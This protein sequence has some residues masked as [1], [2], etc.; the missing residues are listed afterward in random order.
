MATKKEKPQD[1]NLARNRQASHEYEILDTFDAGIELQ[2]TEVKA[3][4]NGRAQLR[5]GYIRI[6]EGQAW[7]MQVHIS[8]YEQGNRANHVPDRRRRLLLHRREIVHLD[9]RVRQGGLT[10]IPLRIYLRGNLIKCE[11]AL[12]R[13]KKLWDKRASLA[14][15]DAKR[16]SDRIASAVM[17]AG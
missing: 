9:M 13:G 10:L 4:R 15:K 11:I 17:R 12:A 8:H 14:A 3:L 16:E 2:G 1:P 5:E 7:L 6:E